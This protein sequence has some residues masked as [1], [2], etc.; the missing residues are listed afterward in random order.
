[1]ADNAFGAKHQLIAGGAFADAVA[2]GLSAGVQTAAQGALFVQSA[3]DVANNANLSALVASWLAAHPSVTAYDHL[4]YIVDGV[5][6]FLTALNA[7][8]A[9]AIDVM[10]APKAFYPYLRAVSTLGVMGHIAF[11]ATS[12][13]RAIPAGF[14]RVRSFRTDGNHDL[15]GGNNGAG[16]F[17]LASNPLRWPGAATL[18]TSSCTRGSVGV[19]TSLNPTVLGARALCAPC[20]AGTFVLT[21]GTQCSNCDA[22]RVCP[23]GSWT[24]G[25]WPSTIALLQPA[26]TTVPIVTGVFTPPGKLDY[27]DT[28]Y[29]IIGAS[30]VV[31]AFLVFSV[32]IL[33]LGHIAAPYLSMVDCFTSDHPVEANKPLVIRSTPTGGYCSVLCFCLM[34]LALIFFGNR[35]Q[36]SKYNIAVAQLLGTTTLLR[37]DTLRV[38]LTFYSIDNVPECPLICSRPGAAIG[39]T[40]KNGR[41]RGGSQMDSHASILVHG[42]I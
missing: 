3:P 38:Q 13:D 10:G 6:T 31:L 34:V 15:I 21:G 29:A 26:K 19:A 11:S 2:A 16:D 8:T 18:P 27:F 24:N 4:P 7:A 41:G 30:L 5:T 23:L 22:S 33:L 37:P 1:V 40:G 14:F 17:A 20:P 12:G 25:G 39:I 36:L 42:S 28:Q 9:A 32:S 35:Y